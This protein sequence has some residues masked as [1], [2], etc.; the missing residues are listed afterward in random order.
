MGVTRPLPMDMP[1]PAPSGLFVTDAENSEFWMDEADSLAERDFD[2]SDVISWPFRFYL[3]PSKKYRI[4]DERKKKLEAIM[5]S[6]PPLSYPLTE[7]QIDRFMSALSKHPDRPV[8]WRPW[9]IHEKDMEQR[10]CENENLIHDVSKRMLESKCCNFVDENLSFV[11]EGQKEERFL[12]LF[13]KTDSV[14]IFLKELGFSVSILSDEILGKGK[15]TKEEEIL[16]N[17][18]KGAEWAIEELEALCRYIEEVDPETGNK[19]RTQKSAADFI[20]LTE[21]GLSQVY[22]N[23]K[24]KLESQS[25]DLSSLGQLRSFKAAQR[26]SSN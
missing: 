3:I 5:D 2:Q 20:G 7:N 19:I 24:M 22:N 17:R 10:F 21:G 16:S 6:L 23:Y 8:G 1:L 4:N 11:P 12:D 14:V 15:R 25:T 9:F 18:V 26:K 13:V